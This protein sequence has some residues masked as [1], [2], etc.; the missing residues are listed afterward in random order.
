MADEWPDAVSYKD[1]PSKEMGCAGLGCRG[2]KTKQELERRGLEH[3]LQV[4][5]LCWAPT[6]DR[7]TGAVVRMSGN[8]I[9]SN[10][11]W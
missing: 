6:E 7:A 4:K 11:T 9:S 2:R 5:K 10:F 1:G 3:G 8:V